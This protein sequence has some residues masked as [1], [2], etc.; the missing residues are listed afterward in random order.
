MEEAASADEAAIEVA[1]AASEEA[2][3][4]PDQTEN[5]QII[6][7]RVGL[8]NDA[9]DG[10]SDEQIAQSRVEAENLGSDP[11]YSYSW[12]L[13]QTPANVVTQSM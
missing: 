2:I 10:Y 12:L 5:R 9:L 3:S 8:A 1:P 7:V 11:G 6:I 4:V 13:Q